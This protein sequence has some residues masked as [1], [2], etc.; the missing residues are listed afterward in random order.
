MV[1]QIP[2]SMNC[3]NEEDDTTNENNE[4]ADEEDEDGNNSSVQF[5]PFSDSSHG[6]SSTDEEQITN[7]ADGTGDIDDLVKGIETSFDNTTLDEALKGFN[8]H[9]EKEVNENSGDSD[10][11]SDDNTSTRNDENNNKP[12]PIGGNAAMRAQDHGLG[13]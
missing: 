12:I 2:E 11:Y 13:I 10:G 5:N 7:D 1:D 6:G 4:G 3:S 8:F 9:Y